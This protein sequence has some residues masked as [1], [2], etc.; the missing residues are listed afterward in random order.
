MTTCDRCG[1]AVGTNDWDI[2]TCTP[3]LGLCDG[4]ETVSHCL[5]HGCIPKLT[6]LEKDAAIQ[7]LMRKHGD[8]AD[9]FKKPRLTDEQIQEIA[10]VA[11]RDNWDWLQFARAIEAKLK[12]LNKC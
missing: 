1:K 12:E 9:T 4:C 5:K 3:K 11:V 8:F 10:F 2:H 7:A 6:A